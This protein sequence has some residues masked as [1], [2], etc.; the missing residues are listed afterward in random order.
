MKR[1][2]LDGLYKRC[3][4]PQKRWGECTDP[5]Y[6]SFRY[7]RTPYKFNLTKRADKPRGYVMP[8]S[9]AAMYQDRFRSEI[10]AGS[11]DGEVVTA[12]SRLTMRDVAKSYGERYID[13][14]SRRNGARRSMRYYING[15]MAVQI[16]ARGDTTVA[17]GDKVLAEITKA[18]IEAL[19]AHWQTRPKGRAK[20]GLVGAN[21][22]LR[23]VRHFF[24]WAIEEG[25]VTATPFKRHGVAVIRLDRTVETGRTR[26]LEPGEEEGLLKHAT[27]YLRDFMLTLLDTGCRKGELLNLQWKDVRMDDNLIVLQAHAT[28]SN[29]MRVV[30]VSKRVKAILEMRRCGPDGED[31]G[32][33]CYVFGNETGERR[34]NVQQIW[35]VAVLRAHGHEPKFVR[36]KLM[37]ESKK[38]FRQIDLHLHDLRRECGSRLLEAGVGIHEV[39]EWL[40]HRDISTTGRYLAITGTSLQRALARLENAQDALV[41]SRK[42][43]TRATPHPK[44]NSP[45][46]PTV[47]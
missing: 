9:E 25:Y 17:V 13:A 36:G 18:D 43:G 7:K 47:N 27:P 21:R 44:D 1:K 12:D 14:P 5:W 41:E 4:C 37:P 2:R 40:G 23:R 33:D 46:R 20:R 42:R 11:F 16:P 30:P 22:A 38:V 10:R 28:K 8:K 3:R 19:R 15:I 45:S 34:G 6:M 31:L 39:R 26:R 29:T 32:A 24:N 35:D